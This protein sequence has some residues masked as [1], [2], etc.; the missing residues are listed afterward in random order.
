MTR[1][2][3]LRCMLYGMFAV[4]LAVTAACVNRDTRPVPGD[5][6]VLPRDPAVVEGVLDNG[7]SY[8]IMGNTE[9]RERVS[10]H[11]AIK[12]GSMY[13]TEAQRGVA[14]FLE[15]ML[16]NGSENFPPGELIKYFQ[17]IGMRFG[18]DANAHTGFYETVYDVVLPAGDTKSLAEGLLV[19]HDYAGGALLLE[20]E[21]DRERGVILA[22][23]RDRDSESYRSFVKSLAFQ[24]PGMR[25]NERHPIGLESVIKGAD[26]A[27]LKG[28]YDAWYRPDNMAVVVVGDVDPAEVAGLIRDRFSS[29]EA[30]A[31]K[32][33]I[34]DDGTFTHM[35]TKTFYAHNPEAGST[36]VTIEVLR[37]VDRQPDT[38]ASRR[39]QLLFD[40]AS[41]ILDNRLEERIGKPGTPFTSAGSGA[42]TYLR[43]VRYGI[44]AAECPADSWEESLAVVDQALRS[45]LA[46]GFTPDE[47]ARVKK[48]MKNA[49]LQAEEKASTRNSRNLAGL[50]VR[51]FTTDKEVVSPSDERRLFEPV[52]D[53]AT[54]EELHRVLK[55]IWSPAHRLVMVE[56][57][58][59]LDKGEQKPEA[60]LL[61]AYE[62]SLLVSATP[63][64]AKSAAAFPYLPAPKA[65]GQIASRVTHDDLGITVVTFDN[66]VVLN[67]K[68]TDFKAKEVLYTLRFGQG[69]KGA[70]GL[71]P[72]L[73]SVSVMVTNE[74]GL[75]RLDRDETARAMA[76]TNTS[77]RYGAGQDGFALSGR[78]TPRE[79]DLMFQVLFTQLTDT[80]LKEEA[81][82]LSVQR[83]TQGLEE[84]E[85][86]VDGVL[87]KQVEAFLTG[88]AARFGYPDT[89]LEGIDFDAVKG[90][91]MPALG[92]APLELSVVGDMDVEE[93]VSLCGQWLGALPRRAPEAASEH[94]L[95]FPAG[96]RLDL[97]VDSAID[98]AV[99]TVAWPTTGMG[100]IHTVRRLS[101]LGSLFSER[102]RETVRENLGAAY[103][104]RAWNNSSRAYP[105]YGA[106]R[107]MITVS[108][109]Q[110]AEVAAAVGEIAEGLRSAPASEDEVRRVVDPV[111]N[112]IA[113]YR[114]TNG[115]WLNSVMQD[116]SR[117]PEK[118]V[119]PLDI[120][121]D[122]A[123][124]TAADLQDLARTYLKASGAATLTV[125]PV[126][127]T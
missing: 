120:L 12:A 11:L 41:R 27:L 58:V 6:P 33:V 40:M 13:E 31:P 20:S 60:V 123:A 69:I 39:E 98:K 36:S 53:A 92:G 73:A 63:P 103:S 4:M 54:P 68:Q 105:E 110:M 70:K 9:P 114:R 29:L 74:S 113:D 64:V 22:E 88:D 10:M 125:R 72:G 14:H 25:V 19:M 28:Y 100:D 44:V 106:L 48:E 16:F 93:V 67:L 117:Y 5:E 47:V 84:M 109:G 2:R 37:H 18:G 102:L 94:G 50:L 34:P 21:V 107:A 112:R 15:H 124:V 122:Y 45:A 86:T 116:S 95:T 30:R 43:H 46:Y 97:S 52:V 89:S 23:K 83:Y 17:R 119:W 26:S 7:M 65:P 96:E 108:P 111:V 126:P 1:K 104:P 115:Y 32:G 59:R 38:F 76:G 77:F 62:K 51:S 118:L 57:N 82:H 78:T 55:E 121:E 99:V 127:S 90:F 3:Y 8:L 79:L 42:G 35:G 61:A 49:L 91:V 85:S 75:G 81:Y 101:I 24:L 66:G 56:G 87:Q 80:R 71:V